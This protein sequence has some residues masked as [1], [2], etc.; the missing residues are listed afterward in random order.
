[1][2]LIFL[3]KILQMW[4]WKAKWKEFIHASPLNR[5]PPCSAPWRT[6]QSIVILGRR[7][8]KTGLIFPSSRVFW[9]KSCNFNAIVPFWLVKPSLSYCLQPSK[10]CCL[11][12]CWRQVDVCQTFP[13]WAQ[14]PFSKCFLIMQHNATL[15]FRLS[16]HRKWNPQRFHVGI[17]M[18]E[19]VWITAF[20][21]SECKEVQDWSQ[22]KCCSQKIQWRLGLRWGNK[23]GEVCPYLKQ[24]LLLLKAR[25]EITW[26]IIDDVA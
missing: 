13:P 15:K 16:C 17:L 11:H 21:P 6:L 1:M 12:P 4:C 25:S 10:S 2:L 9:S 7:D 23:E 24:E 5:Q 20:F 3:L 14:F 18:V 22:V 8:I 19:W 26:N